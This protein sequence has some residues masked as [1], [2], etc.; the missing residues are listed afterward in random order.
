M[1]SISQHNNTIF[2]NSKI[3]IDPSYQFWKN[4]SK[5]LKESKSSKKS[6]SKKGK[7]SKES[8]SSKKS[9]SDKAEMTDSE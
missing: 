9:K 7:S 2:I 8:K 6:K 4:K 1:Q 3:H 5:S